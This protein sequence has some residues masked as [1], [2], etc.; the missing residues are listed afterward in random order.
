MKVLPENPFAAPVNYDTGNASQSI[1]MADFNG[2]GKLDVVYV[3]NIHDVNVGVYLGTGVGTFSPTP[4]ITTA[5]QHPIGVVAGDFNG[6]GKPDIAVISPLDN[7]LDILLGNGDGTF[8]P[9]VP[10]GVDV[11]PHW[12]AVGDFNGDG[13]ADIVTTSLV[14]GTVSVLLGNGDGTLQSAVNYPA[15]NAAWG[16]VVGDFNGDGNA[17]LAVSNNAL[18]ADSVSILLGDGRGGFGAPAGFQTGAYTL[19]LIAADLDGDSRLD[20]AVATDSGVSVLIG[21]GDGTFQPFVNYPAG[22][23]P[24]IAASPPGDFFGSGNLSL[25]VA[26]AVNANVTVL[27]GAGNGTFVA[28]ISLATVGV[29]PDAFAVAD[30]NGD[31]R[32]DLVVANYTQKQTERLSRP[33]PPTHPDLQPRHAPRRHRHRLHLPLLCCRRSRPL[34][35]LH[36]LRLPAHR[37]CPRR[38]HRRHHGRSHNHR[39]LHLHSESRR[40]R[41]SRAKLHRHR[42]HH[43]RDAAGHHQFAL[44]R[45]LWH[46][47]FRHPRHRRHHTHNCTLTAG[48]LPNGLSLNPSTCVLSGTPTLGAVYTFTIGITDSGTPPQTGSPAYS[49]TITYPPLSITTTSLPLGIQNQTYATTNFAASGGSTSYSWSATGLPTGLTLSPAG[50]L[51]GAPTIVGTFAGVNV[52]LTDTVS[53]ATVSKT[54]SLTVY[55]PLLILTSV[56]PQG[57]AGQTIIP[58]PCRPP[59]APVLLSGAP[60]TCPRASLSP[61]RASSAANHLGLTLI[62]SLSP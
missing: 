9:P 25:A 13:K 34:H 30:L 42:F 12:V 22:N 16:V 2:D 24:S 21:N 57:Q 20:L 47:L 60:P 5:D 8:Q 61:P 18:N 51:S 28:P 29:G 56:L 26:T 23:G 15:V 33:N 50:V 32:S 62:T 58:L 43:R 41:H 19:A 52:T 6:D 14:T 1:A 27:P 59:A 4:I 31:G 7:T 46:P 35:L 55:P 53:A 54:F 17:D 39:R 11:S 10:Y 45:S 3:I 48:S 40:Q 37:P 36:Q 49:V 38:L 44:R